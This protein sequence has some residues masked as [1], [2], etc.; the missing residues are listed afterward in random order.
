MDKMYIVTIVTTNGLKEWDYE[1]STT[2]HIPVVAQDEE[3]AETKVKN[4]YWGSEYPSYEIISS[5]QCDD[6]L[7]MPILK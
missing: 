3:E 6:F 7:F 1:P 5:K 2:I 4:R